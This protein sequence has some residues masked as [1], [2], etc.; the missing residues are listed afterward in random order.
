MSRFILCNTSYFTDYKP[1]CEKER[2]IYK[3]IMSELNGDALLK[4]KN[5]TVAEFM[6]YFSP[7]VRDYE[8]NQVFNVKSGAS[9]CY[10]YIPK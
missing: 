1:V 9:S 8:R 6:Q 7:L 2:L 5:M 10:N 3:K 4:A